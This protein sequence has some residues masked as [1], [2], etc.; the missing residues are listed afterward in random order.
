MT[1]RSIVWRLDQTSEDALQV[2]YPW[3]KTYVSDRRRKCNYCGSMASLRE[4]A[5]EL[6]PVPLKGGEPKHAVTLA[7][8]VPLRIW[9]ED[10]FDAMSPFM[11][12]VVR[13][14]YSIEGR[15][16]RSRW[17]LFNFHPDYRVHEQWD[18]FQYK[19]CGRCGREYNRGAKQARTPEWLDA[20]ELLHPIADGVH[21]GTYF[22]D[23]AR[24]LPCWKLAGRARFSEVEVRNIASS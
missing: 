17:A 13:W 7:A 1:L 4:P 24:S 11:P 23:E 8:A 15:P 21:V 3:Q 9:R 20:R 5:R 2:D 22:S 14:E 10:F 16:W 6:G 18:G 19:V 12:P